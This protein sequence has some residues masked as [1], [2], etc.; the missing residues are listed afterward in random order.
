MESGNCV[1]RCRAEFKRYDQTLQL[2][3]GVRC[4]VKRNCETTRFVVPEAKLRIVGDGDLP[5]IDF[6]LECT[7]GVQVHALPCEVKASISM[8]YSLFPI[9]GFSKRI[10]TANFTLLLG[11]IGIEP[12]RSYGSGQKVSNPSEFGPDRV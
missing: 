8:S 11:D 10:L 3:L 4:F 1:E 5:P 2:I 9:R 7:N 6:L 12:F